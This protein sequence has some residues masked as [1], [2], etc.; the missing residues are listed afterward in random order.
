MTDSKTLALQTIEHRQRFLQ[1]KLDA[2]EH[3]V[4]RV[5]EEAGMIRTQLQVLENQRYRL[6][7]NGGGE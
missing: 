2:K 5:I 7:G 6:C 1:S 4:K 3:E